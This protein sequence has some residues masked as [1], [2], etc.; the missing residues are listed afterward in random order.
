MNLQK[1]FSQSDCVF[2]ALKSNN[3]EKYTAQSLEASHMYRPS[4]MY[5][6]SDH[7]VCLLQIVLWR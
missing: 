7:S 6:Y 2:F 3:A 5:K 4:P 1:M